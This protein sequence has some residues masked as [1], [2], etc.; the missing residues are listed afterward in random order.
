VKKKFVFLEAVSWL[1]Q[2]HRVVYIHFT[3]TTMSIT[4]YPARSFRITP[5]K[6]N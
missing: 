3:N 6:R 4:S 1:Q 5:E 2:A